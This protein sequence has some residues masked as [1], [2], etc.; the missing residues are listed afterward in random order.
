MLKCLKIQ[1][2][3]MSFIV[4]CPKCGAKNKI[5]EELLE[6]NVLCG[7]CEQ[8]LPLKD[9]SRILKLSDSDFDAVILNVPKPILVEFWAP[10]SPPCKDF[11]PILEEF[12]KKHSSIIV[13]QINTE[14]NKITTARFDVYS[15]P[16]LILFEK[17]K[18]KGYLR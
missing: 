3:Q 6:K 17:G 12:A 2:R 9:I 18:A 16:T 13:A 7:K 8:P 4:K 14:N 10:W 11:T 1:R 15:I 5:K